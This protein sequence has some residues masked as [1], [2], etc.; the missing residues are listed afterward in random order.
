MASSLHRNTFAG[1]LLSYESGFAPILTRFR[2]TL[3]ITMLF[4]SV[5][6]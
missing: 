3:F 5:Y 4:F 2:S 6:L 1:E